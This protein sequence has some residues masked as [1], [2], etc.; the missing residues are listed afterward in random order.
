MAK[1]MTKELVALKG[2]V[3][4]WRAEKTKGRRHRIPESL[5]ADAVVVA[6][7]KGISQAA[8]ATG[9]AYGDLKKRV[10][11]AVEP[12]TKPAFVSIDMPP[13][14]PSQ[15]PVTVNLVRPDGSQMRIESSVG[16]GLDVAGVVESFLRKT[17]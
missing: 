9:F 11:P 14:P 7:A 5:W 2:R 16:N 3:D 8:R 12:L 6:R 4:Q 13:I 15:A 10:A 1:R 17:T